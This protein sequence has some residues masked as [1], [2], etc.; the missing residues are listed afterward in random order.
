MKIG[1][2]GSGDVG[3]TLASGFIKYGHEV[4]LGSRDITQ[5][6]VQQ[7]LAAKSKNGTLGNFSDA[8]TFGEVV[9]LATP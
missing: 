3:R 9:V 2:I 5:E 1:I 8:A 4:M 6:K 7:W